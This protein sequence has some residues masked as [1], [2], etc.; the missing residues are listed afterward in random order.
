MFKLEEIQK[1]IWESYDIQQAWWLAISWFEE[2][3]KLNFCQWIMFSD[4]KIEENLQTLF[5]EYVIANKKVKIIVVDII[6]SVK[7]LKTT[8]EL[9]Q[10]DLL[11]EWMF[12]WDVANDTWSFVLPDTK[13]IESVKG[14]LENIKKKVEFSSKQINIYKFSTQRFRFDDQ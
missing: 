7:E 2:V 3:G 12:I 4:K 13:W 1:K 6:S 8:Q 10:V 11:R 5:E 9:Q 14:A